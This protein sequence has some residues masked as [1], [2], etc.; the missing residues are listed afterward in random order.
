ML[1]A[2]HVERMKK[3]GRYRCGLV[4]GL[5][6]QIS[7][8]GARSWVLRYELHGKEH[9]MGLGSATEFS[10]GRA[11]ERALA[12]RH[13]LADG[14]D[15]LATKQAAKAA[16][17]LGAARK[18]TF[19]EAAQRYF[20]QHE[21]SWRNVNH[22]LA[23]LNTL[24]A[25]VF[26]VIGDL[27]VAK[28]DTTDILRALEPA[29][30]TKSITADRVRNRIE[31][32]LDWCV[33]RGHRLPGLN[34]ARWKG[35]LDQVLP[36]A[37]KIAPI[38]HHAAM[39]YR[40]LPAL[41]GELRRESSV[42]ARALEFLILTVA[43]TGEVIGAT[44]DEIDSDSNTWIIPGHRM[45]SG[46]EHRVPLSPP[47]MDILHNLPR[48]NG[49]PFVF[50]GKRA[51]AGL[52]RK[53]LPYVMGRLGH[54]RTATVHGFRSSFSNWCHEQTAHST[55]TIEISLAHRVGNETERAYRRTD[56]I[57]KRRQL[58]EAWARFCTTLRMEAKGEVV[59]LRGGGK[60]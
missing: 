20:D 39:D 47:V 51:G 53:A 59:A 8:S 55:H 49:N 24:R 33:V 28:I 4:K 3:P 42:A 38:E 14:V 25:H 19:R 6:L 27:D 60:S 44:W 46:R 56:M 10:L 18:L 35:H 41:M 21:K 9:M 37:R 57:G 30:T 58:L 11:R 26:P 16:A 52:S 45:K 29:W 48:E 54:D 22:R 23:F 34:P 50:I 1:T 2:K 31:A 7:A 12:A 43:R 13:L 32:V 5:L 36:A 40:R 17:K 15:P